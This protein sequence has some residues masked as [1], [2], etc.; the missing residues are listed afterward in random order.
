M[1]G[2]NQFGQGCLN[3]VCNFMNIENFNRY[4]KEQAI[5]KNISKICN[6]A[7]LPKE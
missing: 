6:K 3:T 1:S 4:K 2:Q 7:N 5:N